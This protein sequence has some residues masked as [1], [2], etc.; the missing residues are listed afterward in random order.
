MAYGSYTGFDGM[1]P[2]FKASDEGSSTLG[3]IAGSKYA[4]QTALTGNVLQSTA[5]M[6][7]QKYLADKQLEA[8]QVQA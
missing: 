1:V 4:S 8:A 2:G 7:A 3:D 5:Q 6:R